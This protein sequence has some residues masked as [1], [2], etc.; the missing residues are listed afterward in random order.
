MSDDHLSLETEG[1]A[2]TRFVA[3]SSRWQLFIRFFMNS[4]LP[5][6]TRI[7]RARYRNVVR[8]SDVRQD[9]EYKKKVEFYDSLKIKGGIYFGFPDSWCSSNALQTAAG[10]CASRGYGRRIRCVA[11]DSHASKRCAEYESARFLCVVNCR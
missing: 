11:A 2:N 6:P 7:G 3:Y 4:N 9:P 5:D 8:E 10:E 1:G